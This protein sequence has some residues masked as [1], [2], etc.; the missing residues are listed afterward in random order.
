MRWTRASLVVLALLAL[1]VAPGTRFAAATGPDSDLAPVRGLRRLAQTTNVGGVEYLQ[2]AKLNA[3]DAAEDD[4]FGFSVSIDG[5]TMVIG[6]QYDDDKGTD[7]G[8]AYVFTRNTPGDLASGWTQVA[9]LTAADGAAVDLFGYSVSIDGDTVVIGAY[10]D[11]D[12]GT[13]SGSA[14]VFTRVTA[15]DL[16][17]GWAQVAKLTAGDGAAHDYFGYSVSIDG[18]TVVIGA[19]GDDDDGS[20]SGSAYVFARDTTGDLASNWT[21]VAKLT[22]NVYA[23]G[24]QFGF[25]VSIDGDTMVI[26]AR[27]D[28]D[29]GSN[30]GSAY[31]FTRV[32]AGDLAS[33]WTQVAKLTAVNDGAGG[34]QFGFSVSI[35]GDTIAIGAPYDDDKGTDSG[36]AYVFTRNTAGD[37]AS[38][39]TQVAKLTAVDDGA[40]SDWFGGSVSIDGD[41]VVIGAQY[42]D[43]KGPG[44]GSAYV[45][46]RDTP[47][48]L[49][50][51]WAQV[52]KLTADDGAGGDNFGLSVSIDGDTIAIGAP[53]DDDKG[54]ASGSAHVFSAYFFPCD[55]SSPPANGAVGDCTSVLESGSTCQPTCDQGYAVSGPSACDDGYFLPA[56]CNMF[57]QLA[58]L[59]ADDGAADD[60]FGNSVSIDGDTMVIGAQYDDDK[61]DKSGSAY[62][63]TRDTPGDPT[64]N[65]AKVAKLTAGDG[66][67]TDY[68]GNSVSINGDTM[69]IGAYGDDDKGGN[70]GS[71][72]VFARDTTGDLASNWTQVAKLTASDGAEGDNFGRS[73]SIDGDTMVIGARYDRFG[74]AT[75]GSA[76]VFTRNTAGDLASGWTQVNKL[77]ASDGA[78]SDW[79]G[80]SV[81]IDGDTMVIGADGDDNKGSAYVFTRDTPG[82]LASRWTQVA[83]LTA[84]DGANGDRFGGSVSIDGDTVV[85]GAHGDD[86]KGTDSGSAYVFR[87]ITTGELTSGWTQV[88]KLTAVDDGAASDWFGG[89]VSI[90]GDTMV[91]GARGDDDKGPGSG[92]AYVFTR[93]MAGDTTSG[94]MQVDKLTAVNDG[95]ADDWFGGSVSIDGDTMVI[96]AIGD[97]DKGSISGSAYV[98]SKYVPPCDASSPPAN[99]T[100][101]D[102][103]SELASGS[104][105][106]PTCNQGYAVSGPSV[107]ENSVL[108]PAIC[109]PFC[110]ASTPPANG[111]VGNC[112]DQLLSGT[113]CQPACDSGYF[114]PEPS[115]CDDGVLTPAVCVRYCDASAPPAN[116]GVGDCVEY[117]SSGTTCQP[118]CN[119]G[120]IVSGKTSCDAAGT[121]TAADCRE[122]SCCEQ[123]FAKF[124]FGVA[125]SYGDEL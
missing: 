49:A 91:I 29:K 97:D 17:S 52:A 125:Y 83:K 6:A 48:Y 38:R 8:S 96:G 123:T 93:I 57:P 16:A 54:S 25:S 21:Q 70:S 11:D 105:C 113:T 1:I 62:V 95:A 55:A 24:D 53:Y 121:L 5:D 103:T 102:C 59:T 81:S 18:D 119:E 36:S 77:F 110:N 68:F 9:K 60:R 112:T 50:S 34:D 66:A 99:G 64:S 117:L 47:G 111:A 3:S 109:I 26:G 88:A 14:Y 120:Y 101:G 2:R 12:D 106:Q 32:T 80:G 79:F 10:E 74:S 42:D 30:S 61:G 44:S 31:V 72:Y 107:C 69:V 122:L 67:A 115:V 118:T 100:V 28:G 73:V 82:D 37:L 23:G 84:D 90:D 4:Q 56:V 78:N 63:F 22:L 33:D 7:S 58:K 108:S 40:A 87:R 85:I 65:W 104:T 35:D 92:S 98:F 19:Y 114:A 116:G 45:F 27:Y 39:W 75:L 43:D 46:R 124:G 94:W 15:G 76:Y 13:S 20:G 89:S 51:G 86:D 71:V 41:T